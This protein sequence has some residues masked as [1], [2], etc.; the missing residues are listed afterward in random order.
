[1]AQP[2]VIIQPK[3]RRQ[4]RPSRKDRKLSA[5]NSLKSDALSLAIEF[6]KRQDKRE[7]IYGYISLIMKLGLLTIF[8]ASFVNLAIASHQRIRRQIELSSVLNRE[9]AKHLK[10]NRRFDQLFTIGGES[11]FMKDQDQWIAP[12]SFRVIWR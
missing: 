8:S 12:N 7:L 3:T 1:M 9:A 4:G 5:R 2:Q 10:L 11:R 6:Q